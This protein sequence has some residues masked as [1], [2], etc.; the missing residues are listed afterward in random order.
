MMIPIVAEAPGG[1]LHSKLRHGTCEPPAGWQCGASQG[2]ANHP[3]TLAFLR[4]LT[5]EDLMGVSP[6]ILGIIG[7]V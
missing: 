1:L 5:V 3:M 6:M 2:L 7:W 4:C